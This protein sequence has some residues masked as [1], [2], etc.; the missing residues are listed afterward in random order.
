MSPVAGAAAR[1]AAAGT[2]RLYAAWSTASPEPEAA[3]RRCEGVAD[4]ARRRAQ[5]SQSL[6]LTDGATA[7]LTAQWDGAADPGTG[8]FPGHNEMIYDGANCY[9]RTAAGWTGFFLID[10]GGPVGPNDP[11]WPLDALFGANEDAVATGPGEVRGEPVTHFRLTVDLGRADAAV[12]AGVSVPS[13]PYRVLRALPAEVWLDAAG[14][15]RRIAVNSAPAA[16]GSAVW[17]VAELWDFG[18]AAD[19]TPPGPDEILRPK[20]AY[21]LSEQEPSGPEG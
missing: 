13:G 19:I 20:D 7:A 17:S 3:D 16:G 10:P 8:D 1:T 12:P 18:V 6:F 11:L 2:A 14:R 21:R 5:V 15:A 9:I 4:L